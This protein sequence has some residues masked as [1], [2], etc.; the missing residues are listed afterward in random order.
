M[1]L[2]GPRPWSIEQCKYFTDYQKLRHN[3]LP[4]LTGLNQTKRNKTQTIF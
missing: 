1:S 4:G 2:I 3:V